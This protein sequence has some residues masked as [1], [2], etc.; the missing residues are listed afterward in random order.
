M[1]LETVTDFLPK[2]SNKNS[3][4]HEGLV[5]LSVPAE[6]QRLLHEYC[7]GVNWYLSY[8]PHQ[9]S[10]GKGI[11]Q[12][13][14]GRRKCTEKSLKLYFNRNDANFDFSVCFKIYSLSVLEIRLYI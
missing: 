9:E 5:R 11:H 2:K 13:S 10:Q 7:K 8:Q 4:S 12:A 6:L 1:P 14:A 3:P